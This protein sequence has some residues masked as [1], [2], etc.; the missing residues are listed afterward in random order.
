MSP[1]FSSYGIFPLRCMVTLFCYG[2]IVN[3]LNHR[4]MV[5]FFCCGYV[6]NQ[7]EPLEYSDPFCYGYVGSHLESSALIPLS[8]YISYGLIIRDCSSIYMTMVLHI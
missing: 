3:H 6:V 5:T 1:F 7:L 2:Y 4:H 8:G